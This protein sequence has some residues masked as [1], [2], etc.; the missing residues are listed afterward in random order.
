MARR[1]LHYEAAFEAYVRHRRIPYV[2]VDEAKK[3]LLPRALVGG[4]A[5]KS[6]DF[7]V[8]GQN[9]NLLA[10]VKGRRVV[11]GGR[12]ENWVTREDVESLLKWECLF[13]SGFEAAFIFVYHYVEQPPDALFEELFQHQELWYG[14]RVVTV[15]DYAAA[16]RTRS[17]R[18]RTIDIARPTFDRISSPFAA[19]AD[20][21]TFGDRVPALGVY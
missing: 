12:L 18:W 11:G 1:S 3:S 9:G 21:I 7:V 16:M 10:E 17:E 13:G 20:N 19:P 2:A 6:F 15:R 8:Y 14:L 5:L 4:D